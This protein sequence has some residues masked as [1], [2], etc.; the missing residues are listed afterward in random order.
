V[1]CAAGRFDEQRVVKW[2]DWSD[3]FEVT[4][5]CEVCREEDASLEF[6]WEAIE[7]KVAHRAEVK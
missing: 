3:T 4:P 6:L 5:V 1:C 2:I 7:V